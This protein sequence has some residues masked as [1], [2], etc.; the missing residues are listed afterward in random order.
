MLYVF[1]FLF[2]VFNFDSSI[3]L[4]YKNDTKLKYEN[5]LRIKKRKN[6]GQS[7]TQN[8]PS[9]IKTIEVILQKQK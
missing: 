5:F 7:L 9:T 8:D 2:R 6:M 3:R 4:C 1:E